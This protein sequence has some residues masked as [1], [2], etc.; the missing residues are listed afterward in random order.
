MKGIS[1]RKV[2]ENSIKYKKIYLDWQTKGS[3]LQELGEKHDVTKQRMW[4]IITRCKLGDGD[5]YSG[6]SVARNKW[7]QIKELYETV[8]EAEI[9]Y[10]HWLREKNIKLA[11]DNMTVAPHS[12]LS[13]HKI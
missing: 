4:Q 8:E 13:K 6:V 10:K 9:H 7:L 2:L 11:L 12:G 5:Y 1:Q 3:T